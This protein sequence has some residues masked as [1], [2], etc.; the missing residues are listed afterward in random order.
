M[1]TAASEHDEDRTLDSLIPPSRTA[2][3]AVQKPGTIS[4]E[5]PI[6]IPHQ[7]TSGGAGAAGRIFLFLIFLVALGAAF[8]A[9]RRYKGAIPFL[10]AS[11][12]PEAQASPSPAVEDPQT[13]FDRTRSEIDSEPK[14]WLAGDMTRELAAQNILNPLDSADPQ[15][16]YLYGRASMLAGNNADAARAF[17]QAIVRSAAAPSPVNATVKKDATLALAAL[18]LKS[19]PDRAKALIYL[20]ELVPKP[21]PATSP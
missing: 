19:E 14:A 13:K 3:P 11:S 4:G 16:L 20:D 5:R 18:A 17:E 7:Q 1:A 10:S 8:Y 21:S 15:F 9:G 6:D 2:F 12:A